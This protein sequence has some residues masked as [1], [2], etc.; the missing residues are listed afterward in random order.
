MSYFLI[1]PSSNMLL[2]S[3]ISFETQRGKRFFLHWK[4][5]IY[6]PSG[7]PLINIRN[8]HFL[9]KKR[10]SFERTLEMSIV[11]PEGNAFLDIFSSVY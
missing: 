2:H 1:L 11:K 5:Q 9:L 4:C 3:N 8:G 7:F 6:I 10:E